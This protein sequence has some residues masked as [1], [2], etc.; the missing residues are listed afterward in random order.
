MRLRF[1]DRRQHCL[2]LLALVC[3]LASC[4]RPAGSKAVDEKPKPDRA[5]AAA[6]PSASPPFAASSTTDLRASPEEWQKWLDRVF[7]ERNTGGKDWLKF[8]NEFRAN[9]GDATTRLT[10]GALNPRTSAV[11]VAVANAIAEDNLGLVREWASS[12]TGE[13]RL[14]VALGL[15]QV[16]A[17]SAPVEASKW[18]SENPTIYA[19]A[20]C[21]QALVADWALSDIRAAMDWSYRLPFGPARQ[22]A[23]QTLGRVWGQ[24]DPQ[25]AIATIPQIDN[26]AERDALTICIAEGWALHEPNA[27]VSWLL[28]T[29]LTDES[30]RTESLYGAFSDLA[31]LDAATAEHHMNSMAAGSNRDAAIMG[32]IDT[33][34]LEKPELVIP[35][36]RKLSDDENRAETVQKLT[37]DWAQRYPSLLEKLK[38]LPGTGN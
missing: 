26:P 5:L 25:N 24:Q 1:S 34:E 33:L 21:Q 14:L 10:G 9:P 27:A 8:V 32:F 12:L 23:T 13:S 2:L 38:Q 29:P 35:W 16:W 17:H 28:T 4:D 37:E 36:V 15:I 6:G 19:D 30:K 20:R 18:M 11:L 3:A 22:T 31:G 7:S